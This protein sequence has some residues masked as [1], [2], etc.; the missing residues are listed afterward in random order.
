MVKI[1]MTVLWL[2]V[3]LCVSG[4][5]QYW[6]QEG[7]TFKE[8]K[9]DRDA[10]LK[11]LLRHSDLTQVGPYEIKFMEQCMQEKGYRLAKEGELPMY[12]RRETPETSF[13]YRAKG[14]AGTMPKK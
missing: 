5:A 2:I 10:C 13:Y 14:L 4:C 12:V 9:Q 6:Y 1:K 8:C 3:C 11:E 7:K